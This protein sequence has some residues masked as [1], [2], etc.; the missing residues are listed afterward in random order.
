MTYRERTGLWILSF[1]VLFGGFAACTARAGSP[2]TAPVYGTITVCYFSPKCEFAAKA[3][4][5]SAQKRMLQ[6]IRDSGEHQG[7]INDQ[8]KAKYTAVDAPAFKIT[9]TSKQDMTSVKFTML[10]DS[11]EGVPQ[12]SFTIGKLDAGKSRVIVP[13]NSNDKKT[14]PSGGIFYFQG[15]GDPLD[16]SDAVPNQNTVTFVLTA[17]IGTQALTS[18]NIVAGSFAKA[19][20]DGTVASINFLGG[21]GNADGPCADCVDPEQIGTI[22]ASAASTHSKP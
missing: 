3:V 13:G 12:D 5:P 7:S 8:T 22:S 4:S 9:N 10:A 21:P 11:A 17:K 19:S 15:V 20:A 6:A 1:G 16:T 2:D 18:G 14:H